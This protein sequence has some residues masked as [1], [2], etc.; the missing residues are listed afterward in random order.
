M[1]TMAIIVISNQNVVCTPCSWVC[2]FIIGDDIFAAPA[3][4]KKLPSK[5]PSFEQLLDDD[6][7]ELFVLKKDEPNAA[8]NSV[9][10]NT[11]VTL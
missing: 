10:S 3:K 8:S 6:S 5:K 2:L 4:P 1:A 11:E 7:D 9:N